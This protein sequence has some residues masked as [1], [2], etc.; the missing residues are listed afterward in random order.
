MVI[1][2]EVG[3]LRGRGFR[4]ICLVGVGPDGWLA[5]W[6]LYSDT[7]DNIVPEGVERAAHFALAMLE[8]LD[9]S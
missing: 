1:V 4:G 6:H 8:T 2:E 7:V 9:V 5:N 3:T